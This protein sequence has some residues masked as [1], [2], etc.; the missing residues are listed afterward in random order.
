MEVVIGLIVF[1]FLT[2]GTGSYFRRNIYKEVDRLEKWKIDIMNKSIMDE[3]SKVK[4]LKMTGQAEEMFE[5]WRKEWDEIITSQ[6]PK[7]EELL[8]DAEECADKYRFKKSKQTLIHIQ[9]ALKETEEQ[10]D[11]IIKEINDLVSS[12]EKNRVDSEEAKKLFKK[13]KKSLITQSHA[14]GN[15]QEKLENQLYECAEGLKRFEMETEAGNYLL[16]REVLLEQKGILT[17]L[18]R[19]MEDI[20]K[21]LTEC[22]TVIP[23][24]LQELRLGYKEMQEKGYVLP[25]IDIEKEIQKMNKSLETFKE[26]LNE[27]NMDG[28]NEGF[29]ELNDMI[30]ALYDMLESEVYASHFVKTETV[31]TGQ[32]LQELIKEKQ[33]TKQE[34]NL[35]KQTYE[36]TEDDV[37]KLREIEKNIQHLQNQYQQIV[38]NIEKPHVAHSVLKE[39]LEEFHRQLEETKE[40]HEKYRQMLYA[41][42]K[43]ELEARDKVAEL[44]RIMSEIKRSIQI[45]NVPG[46]PVR[47]L[48]QIQAAQDALGKVYTK[49][50][51]APLNMVAVHR[52]L[53]DAVTVVN[54]LKTET[55]EMI[56]QVYLVEKVIQYGNRYRSQNE[57][58]DYQLKE[59]EQQFRNFEYSKSLEQATAAIEAIEPGAIERIQSIL[60]EDLK[61]KS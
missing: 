15:T 19:K 29:E 25:H 56:E 48:D 4:E 6:L 12:E 33:E 37:E 45:S 43:D 39:E 52:D 47:F 59:A 50:S 13:L 38:A 9:T 7:V 32:K 36:L 26:Q 40:E 11:K 23:Q 34:A 10:I 28:L 2:F 41:L 58:L 44:K 14:F 54:T 21:F 5:R 20:P 35:V 1:I 57:M 16:A 22:Q 31:S 42:R 3:F 55:E 27:A 51:E 49:L 46:L 8:F 61:V 53:E 17:K 60:E 24:K 30:E 18:E